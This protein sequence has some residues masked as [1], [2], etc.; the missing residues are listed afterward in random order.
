[1]PGWFGPLGEK[2]L[3]E[4]LGWAMAAEQLLHYLGNRTPAWRLVE[5][6]FLR[7]SASATDRRP[8]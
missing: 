5:E 1:M 8:D 3:D 7:S 4:A 6:L 2:S